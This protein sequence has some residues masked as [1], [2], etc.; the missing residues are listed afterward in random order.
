MLSIDE[1]KQPIAADIDAFEEKF[2]SSMQS[3]VPLL[4]RITHYIVKRKGKQI[5]PMFVFFSASICGGITEATHRGAALVELLHTATLVH[6]DVVDNSYQRRGFFS[7]NA[8]WKNKIAVL[9]GDFLLSKGLL[10]SIENNDFKLLQIVSEAVKQMSEGELL[11]VEK[12]RRMDV[13]EP[14][15]YEVIRQKTASL[16]ASCCACGAASA[17]ADEETIEK[18]RSFGE[19]IGIAFQIKDDMFDFGTDD[20]GKPL[21]IDIKEKK[22][23]LPLIYSLNNT[24]SSE[25][26]RIINLVKNHNDDPKKIEQIIRFVKESGG[27]QY[28]ETQMKKYQDEAFEILNTFPKSDSRESLEQ[29]VRFTTERNK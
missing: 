9:V 19:K 26:K 27:L 23:T 16:I 21:G 7:I 13:D 24:T 4:D 28:A 1:I 8:L 3:S 29:L 5:R 10:L 12:V 22:V 15:Y 2:K 25:R 20:V 6:D 14:I 11:Q 17:G 18:M